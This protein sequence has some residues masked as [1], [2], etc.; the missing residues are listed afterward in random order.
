MSEQ[1]LPGTEVVPNYRTPEQEGAFKG[2]GAPRSHEVPVAELN[3]LN[4]HLFKENRWAEVFER[5]R[6]EDPVHLNE[7]DLAGRY[8]SLTRYEDI[9]EVDRDW[10]TFSSA[11]GI[12]LGFQIGSEVPQGVF[13]GTNSPFIAQDPPTHGAQRKTVNGIVSPPN[14]ARL[15][16]LIRERTIKVLDALPEGEAFDWVDTVSI[17]LTTLMLA[18]LFDF[19]L[20]DRRKLTRWSDVVFAIP[21]PGGIVETQAQKREEL[22]A[23]VEYFARLWEERKANPGVDLV[24]ML[25]HGEATRDSSPMEHLGNLL[26]LI[27][28]GND[29]TRNTMSGS[30]YALNRFPEQYDKLIAD[31]T[32]IPNMVAEVI[33]WQTP[34]AY[35]RRTANRDVQIGGKQILKDDQLLMWY[36]SGNRDESVFP[37]AD[38]LDIERANAR[39]HLS[40]GFGIH[41]CMGNR[42]A[43]LQLRVLWEEILPRFE[44]I[45]VLEEP[46]RTFS[47]FV[48]GYTHLPV[49]VQRTEGPGHGE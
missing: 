49:K 42:L 3:P 2:A 10:E 14:L 9:A 19:P 36:V 30:V 4:A 31:P 25:A 40:F 44:K 45:E 16:P 46:Q 32:L 1:P 43:E 47:S 33:R 39:Q 6:A 17:E 13:M 8:W 11:N 27:V 7:L 28:G 22:L 23:C 18:T 26:L 41:R 24:S 5:L 12:T 21:E 15:E 34:L 35:M 20:E 29:T 37:N 38:R 48:K